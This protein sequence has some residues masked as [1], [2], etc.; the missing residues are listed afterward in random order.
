[1]ADIV[2]SIDALEVRLKLTEQNLNTAVEN[3]NEALDTIWMLLAGLLVFFMHAGFS[4]L[5]AGSVRL[6]NVQNILAKNLVVATAGFLCWWAVGYALALGKVDDGNRFIGSKGFFMEEFWNDKSIFRMWFFQGAFCATGATIVSGAM[7]ERVQIKGFISFTVVMTSFI[8]PVVVYWCWSGQGFLNY[9]DENKQAVSVFGAKYLDFAGSGVV[10]MVGGVA[11]LCGAL[12]VG[13]RKGRF[14]PDAEE[15]EFMPHNIPFCV[16][17]TFCLWVG[18]FGFNPG[19]TMEMHTKASAQTAG[20]AAVNSVLSPCVS[21]LVVFFFKGQVLSPRRLDVG[22]FCNGIL[23]GLVA[24]T[25]GCANLRP[26]EAGI[27]GLI[28]GFAYLGASALALRLRVDDVVDAF[29]VHGANGFWGIIALGLFGNPSEGMGGNGAFFGGN[30]LQTQL[31]AALVISAWTAVMSVAVL[32]PMKKLGALRLGEDFQDAGADAMEHSPAKAYAAGA[33][34][35]APRSP[36]KAYTE[37]RV[38]QC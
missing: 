38:W 21:G 36:S 34:P 16:L 18:W 22:A 28:A 20:L 15:D 27:I 19:S 14:D 29:A 5:E 31:M 6:K 37:D 9:K 12:V 33:V 4:F 32:V 11:A 35:E 23:A 24:I 1:M 2:S 3:Y 25:A 13:P 10:H 26:W 17:G 7:A 30:Q 8:Y